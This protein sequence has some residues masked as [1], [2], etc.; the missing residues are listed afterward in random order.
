LKVDYG[1]VK[2]ENL[3]DTFVNLFS[4]NKF[5]DRNKYDYDETDILEDL[6][7]I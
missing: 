7:P 2:A 4:L 3:F 1:T 5:R 6:K